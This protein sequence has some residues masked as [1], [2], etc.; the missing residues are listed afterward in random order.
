MHAELA[1]AV[2]DD[3]RAPVLGDAGAVDRVD[4]L[5]RV[6]DDDARRH[7]Q[8]RAAASRTRRS[9][10]PACGGRSSG[11]WSSRLAR[12]RR[13]RERRPP[14]STGSRR[15]RRSAGSSSTCTTV[16][17]LCTIRPARA[18]SGSVRVT[19]S[20]HRVGRDRSSGAVSSASRSSVCRLVVQ[21][22]ERRHTGSSEVSVGASAASR[23]C[24]SVRPG[25][26][27]PAPCSAW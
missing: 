3:E 27:A 20:R 10:P 2:A 22:P 8:E 13:A 23:S 6:L 21:N 9:P 17:A 24:S 16:P 4:D 5:E 1:R 11:A 15:A 26:P 19:T 14:A 18:R 25:Q 12:A 7:V